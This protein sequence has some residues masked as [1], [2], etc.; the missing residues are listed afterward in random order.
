MTDDT[1][2]PQD[3][4][5]GLIDRVGKASLATLHPQKCRPYTSLVLIAPDDDGS[6]VMML[7]DLADHAKNLAAEGAS[8][9]LLDGTSATESLSGPRVSMEGDVVLITDEAEITRLKAVFIARHDEARIYAQ[10]SDFRIYKM[11]VNRLHLIAGFGQIHWLEADEVLGV[12]G[13]E[14]RPQD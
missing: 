3:I 14:G 12:K 8:S 7:S 9:L 2:S 6:P 10:F 11:Q 13:G 4:A 1:A 5:R